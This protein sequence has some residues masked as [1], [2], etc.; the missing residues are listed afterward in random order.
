M[1]R[2]GDLETAIVDRLAQAMIQGAP[3]FQ[4]VR[5]VSGGNRR[6][7]LDALRRERMPAARVGF[8]E[9]PTAPEVRD[10]VRGAKFAVLVG[11]RSL[12]AGTDPRNGDSFT[13]GAFELM[14]AVRAELDNL[15]PITGFRLLNLHEKFVDADDRVAIYE[16]LYRVWPIVVP[17]PVL[18]F[19]GVLL[20]GSDSVM[21][22]EAGPIG[23]DSIDIG[24]HGDSGT[25]NKKFAVGRRSIFWRGQVRAATHTAMNTIETDVE[26]KITSKTI[27]DV[28]E[29]SDRTFTS[30][31]L[32]AYFRRGRRRVEDGFI[33]QDAELLFSH[34]G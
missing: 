25:Y 30:C 29:G 32:E 8:T 11:A 16:S 7:N 1:S 15:E 31:T 33:V 28:T 19:G 2:L 21:D 24:Y 22:L 27:G 18:K 3:A 20:L 17:G 5:G 23:V 14:D 12:R 34:P 10:A 6:S 13:T 4:S 26:T 9:D